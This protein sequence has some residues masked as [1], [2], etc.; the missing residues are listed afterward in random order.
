MMTHGLAAAL[1]S[2]VA[3]FAA[4]AQ[5]AGASFVGDPGHGKEIYATCMYC[6]GIDV[7]RV[8]PMH[9]GLFGRTAGT[10]PGY[11]YS[12]PMKQAGA[13]G[14]IWNAQTLDIYLTNPQKLVPGT[15]MLF[16]GIADAEARADLIAYLK[17]ATA[18]PLKPDASR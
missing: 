17:E 8:G 5:A 9:R 14:L 3:H 1:L 10:L 6:H 13:K 2:V 11:A 18:L 7:N 4:S 12:A 16:G 15:K